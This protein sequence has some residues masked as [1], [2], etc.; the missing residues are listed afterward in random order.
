MHS[1]LGLVLGSILGAAYVNAGPVYKRVNGKP[2]VSFSLGRAEEDPEFVL[3]VSNRKRAEQFPVINS[4][5][6]RSGSYFT[7]LTIGNPS[8]QYS[9][10]MDT[11]SPYTWITASNVTSFNTSEVGL[12]YTDGLNTSALREGVCGTY[13]CYNYTS[14]T[15]E[16]TNSSVVGFLSTYG[17]NTTVVG[18]NVVDELDIGG[19]SL[20]NFE[21][22]LGT[23]EFVSEDVPV[24]GGI[25]GLSPPIS[26]YGISDT[27]RLVDFAAPTLLEQLKTAGIVTSTAF[28]LSLDSAGGELVIG[29]Y[30][31]DKYT[32]DMHWLSISNSGSNSYY[33]VKIA[34]MSINTANTTSTTSNSALS[35]FQKRNTI[36]TSVS[37]NDIIILDSGTTLVYI[38]SDALEAIVNAYGGI[39]DT[40]SYAYVLCDSISDEDTITFQFNNNASFNISVNDMVF[41][42][43]NSQGQ[44][45][46]Y[47][48]FIPTTDTYI[49]GQYFLRQVYTVYDWD[50]QLIGLASIQNSTSSNV[51]DIASAV[52]S[53]VSTTFSTT[54]ASH[55]YVSSVDVLSSGSGEPEAT[56]T[57]QVGVTTSAVHTTYTSPLT[58]TTHT[59]ATG[60]GAVSYGF[61]FGVVGAVLLLSCLV[62]A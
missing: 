50:A 14:T 62:M 40:S 13:Q 10:V 18:F 21:F 17:D 28:S 27:N 55:T 54:Y 9:L 5:F 16:V 38:P 36:S 52:S 12:S 59:T 6:D 30:D 32:G 20:N 56:A 7:N 4:T 43:D 1:L 57:S 41:Y 53:I 11:G 23:R 24:T 29:G 58:A 35:N 26:I 25:L 46:C 33:G 49:L 31:T 48:A 3:D 60:S 2:V 19:L 39:L 15:L 22:G 44:G 34:S 37:I 61:R 45:I 47:L 8:K 42:R 51:I